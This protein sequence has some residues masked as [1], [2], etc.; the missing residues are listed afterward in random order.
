MLV[1]GMSRCMVGGKV[2]ERVGVRCERGEGRGEV[3]C[4]LLR[5]RQQC[6]CEARRDELLRT[7]CCLFISSQAWY[8][9]TIIIKQAS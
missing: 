1:D 2:E 3:L 5:G 8:Q 6:D 7:S 9:A 4:G